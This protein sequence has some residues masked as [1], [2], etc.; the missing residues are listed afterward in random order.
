M[1]TM[2]DLMSK[3]NSNKRIEKEQTQKKSLKKIYIWLGILG[4][5]FL[6]LIVVSLVN[7]GAD[8]QSD[9][10]AEYKIETSGNDTEVGI[11]ENEEEGIFGKI[12]MFTWII[13]VA[14]GFMLAKRVFGR[15]WW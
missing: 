5:F 15:H 2:K 1:Q 14:V 7:R 6:V 13:I 11:D 4:V 10:Q 3:L 8:Y 12:D 9:Y